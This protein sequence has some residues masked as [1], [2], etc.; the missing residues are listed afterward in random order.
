MDELTRQ[1]A[2]MALRLSAL[3]PQA[4][5]NDSQALDVI[6][7]LALQILREVS[8]RRLQISGVANAFDSGGTRGQWCIRT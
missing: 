8:A 4:V 5:R 1:V 7:Q 6:E 2:Q 3:P